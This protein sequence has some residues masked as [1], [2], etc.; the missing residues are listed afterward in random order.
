MRQPA[1]AFPLRLRRSR[2][3]W[4]WWLL[5]SVPV[6]VLLLGWPA[7][8]D[9]SGTALRLFGLGLLSA[10]AGLRW[11]RHGHWCE[12]L[13]GLGSAD[14]GLWLMLAD[15]RRLGPVRVGLQHPWLVI[16]HC[17]GRRPWPGPALV[18][19]RDMLAPGELR[20]LRLWLDA[21]AGTGPDQ[22]GLQG[23]P[24]RAPR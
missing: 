22:G 9:P 23:P 4:L 21:H 18:L 14:Q 17:P 3:L 24:P 12:R 16:L 8:W 19:F 1:A 7:P 2:A 15:D 20:R 11:R 5:V 13:R 6:G 10:D